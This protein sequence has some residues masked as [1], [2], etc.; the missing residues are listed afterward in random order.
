M[1]DTIKTHHTTT[2]QILFHIYWVLHCKMLSFLTLIGRTMY[3]HSRSR[4]TSQSKSQ[5]VW[6]KNIIPWKARMND[7]YSFLVMHQ[8]THSFVFFFFLMHHNSWIK[9]CVRAHFSCDNLCISGV[10]YPEKPQRSSNHISEGFGVGVTHP[11]MDKARSFLST[12]DVELRG[13]GAW[14][15]FFL[16]LALP[17]FLPFAILFF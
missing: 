11:S 4:R 1:H 2:H 13:R 15:C 14:G 6:N 12:Y 3:F 10:F 5:H 17:T 9:S 16:S 7:F 8:K